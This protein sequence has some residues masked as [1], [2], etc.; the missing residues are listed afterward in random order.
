MIFVT[1]VLIL[2]GITIIVPT[3]PPGESIYV[4][5]GISEVTSPISGISGVVLVNAIING[6]FYGTIIL[7]IYCLSSRPKK[8]KKFQPEWRTC[9][10]VNR[11]TPTEYVPPKT[12]RKRPVYKANAAT[13]KSSLD[14]KVEAIEGIGRAYGKRLRKSG[15][16]T[17]D[18]LLKAGS[19]RDGQNILATKINVSP[20]TILKW[21]YRADLFRISGIGKQYS[22]LLESTGVNSVANLS[23]R[24]PELLHRDLMEIN[25][26]KNLVRRIPPQNMV[27]DWIDNA[28]TLKPVIIY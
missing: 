1:S 20:S 5:L 10:P 14:Q 8:R 3:L 23:I 17:V 12:I 19:T 4:F 15:V 13:T 9:Y 22:S 21:V 18:D 11:L 16:K 7:A 25:R 27:K 2:F 26:K 24:N 28:K 6:L